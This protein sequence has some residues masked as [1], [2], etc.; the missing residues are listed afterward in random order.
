MVNLNSAKKTLENIPDNQFSNEDKVRI[1][2]INKSIRV[3]QAAQLD[4]KCKVS[5][6]FNHHNNLNYIDRAADM[7]LEVKLGG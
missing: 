6:I 2:E 1:E 4:S 7:K 3:A 5:N